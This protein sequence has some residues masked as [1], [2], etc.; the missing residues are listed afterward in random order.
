[1]FPVQHLGKSISEINESS[2][3][4]RG[5]DFDINTTDIKN[6]LPVVVVAFLGRETGVVM[7]HKK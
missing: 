2:V 6:I 1:M 7:R 4:R 3:T 5:G